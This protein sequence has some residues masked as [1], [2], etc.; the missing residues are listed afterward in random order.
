MSHSV[1]YSILRFLIWKKLTKKTTTATIEQSDCMANIKTFAACM[2][3]LENLVCWLQF[4]SENRFIKLVF[5]QHVLSAFESKW[6]CGSNFLEL[7]KNVISLPKQKGTNC[8]CIDL[9]N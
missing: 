2:F 8:D 9:S 7:I 1:W 5:K 3:F 6:R 4:G